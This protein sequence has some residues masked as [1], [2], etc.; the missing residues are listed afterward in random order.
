MHT[1]IICRAQIGEGHTA[2]HWA[3]EG[4]D[5][6]LTS[7]SNRLIIGALYR[8]A[9][10]TGTVD[11]FMAVYRRKREEY[12]RGLILRQ[13]DWQT[14]VS[15]RPARGR[16]HDSWTIRERYVGRAA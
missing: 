13:R 1:C 15:R 16:H 12:V 2:A 14:K 5:V 10:R 8:E 11:V 4:I 7:P 9:K 3:Y 6:T